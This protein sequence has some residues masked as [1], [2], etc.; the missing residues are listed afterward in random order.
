VILKE[1]DEISMN[2]IRERIIEMLERCRAI[3]IDDEPY[4]SKL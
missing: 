1:W 4:R 2:E 3:A